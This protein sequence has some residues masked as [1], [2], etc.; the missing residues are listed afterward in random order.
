MERFATS[1]APDGTPW[2][3]NAQ[4]TLLRFLDETSGNF[5]KKG[6]LSAKGRERIMGKKPLIGVTGGLS[7]EIFYK[8]DSHHAIVAS[9]KPY[10]AVQQFGARRGQFG[11]TRRGAPIPW[12]DIPARPF[13][14]LSDDDRASILEKLAKYLERA[15]T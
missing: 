12:G 8:S 5:T 2:A 14:G 6:R 10:A 11:A 1:R 7:S 3:P 4:S 9:N 15:L 13:F